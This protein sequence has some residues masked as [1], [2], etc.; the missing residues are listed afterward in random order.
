MDDFDPSVLLSQ[1]SVHRFSGYTGS[2]GIEFLE[3]GAG[4]GRMQ[5][6]RG[7]VPWPLTVVGAALSAV[8]LQ[9]SFHGKTE[10]VLR[11]RRIAL[12]EAFISFKG[13]IV[14]AMLC[15]SAPLW[16]LTEYRQVVKGVEALAAVAPSVNTAVNWLKSVGNDN[17]LELRV[18]VAQCANQVAYWDW[19]FR[20]GF[21]WSTPQAAVGIT[22]ISFTNLGILRGV[23]SAGRAASDV[24]D[25][26]F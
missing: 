22:E 20:H 2:L 26:I 13:D 7:Y 21:S 19:G 1:S 16:T 9:A 12:A 17:S 23:L 10:W 5:G 4:F 18:E 6:S 15:S 3:I 11:S 14:Y 25:W 24:L 8:P